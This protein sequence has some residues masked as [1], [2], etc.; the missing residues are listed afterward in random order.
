MKKITLLLLLINLCSISWL[1]AQ[2]KLKNMA[3]DNALFGQVQINNLASINSMD[4]DYSPVLLDDGIIFTS[5]RKDGSTSNFGSWFNKKYADLFFAKR[6]E[7]G[8][9]QNPT[10]LAGNVNS[11]YH[12]GIATLNPLQS[13]MYFSRNTK[14]PSAFSKKSIPLKIYSAVRKGENWTNVE[15]AAIDQSGYSTCHPTLSADG[16]KMY[17][18]SDREGGFGGLDIYVTT[19]ENNQWTK[20]VNL[21]D[22][23][24]TAGNEIFPFIDEMGDLYFSSNGHQAVSYTH[25]T[26]PT[27]A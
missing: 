21:G 17:F 22:Q 3:V 26:L 15:E 11:K 14:R 2:S 24:N 4:L 27:K 7:D 18:A 20:P 16:K 23:V 8:S 10:P 19:F 25:L 1:S 9:Y 5:T 12:D 13:K 6:N